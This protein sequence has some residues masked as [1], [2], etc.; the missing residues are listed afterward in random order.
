M[1]SK[2]RV[3]R[4]LTTLRYWLQDKEKSY[5]DFMKL[6]N[7]TKSNL[8]QEPEEANDFGKSPVLTAHIYSQE[9]IAAFIEDKQFL[10]AF[11]GLWI[12]TPDS[13]IKS[14]LDEALRGLDVNVDV[15]L[16]PN[17]GRNFGPLLVE[18]SEKLL[19]TESFIHIHSKETRHAPRIGREWMN[20]NLEILL[21]PNGIKRI[22]NIQKDPNIGL[23]YSDASDL[24]RGINYR[25]GRSKDK[26]NEIVTAN[27]GLA[28]I[29]MQGTLS[30]PAGGMFWAK[31]KPLKKLL[32]VDW[33]YEMFPVELN[34]IDG[35]LQHGIER[36]I[37]ELV[38][39]EGYDHAIHTKKLDR[40][41]RVTRRI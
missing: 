22:S 27:P 18:F 29:K 7:W 20:R 3:G 10:S 36:L 30:F 24:L 35:T 33:N 15:R 1:K 16:T 34:Q 8:I 21:S 19:Q 23:M 39:A 31:T 26:I 40:F 4:K 6:P 25:W 13:T 37:G 28:H 11:S 12:T 41:V 9:F 5:K 17:L 14:T 38:L 32:D 2:Y